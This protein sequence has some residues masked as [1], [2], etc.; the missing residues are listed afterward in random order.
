MIETRYGELARKY[1]LEEKKR[2]DF[3]KINKCFVEDKPFK[4]YSMAK[5]YFDIK[6]SRPVWLLKKMS[7]VIDLEKT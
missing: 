2:L 4:G 7:S 6:D 3:E 5:N 1:S